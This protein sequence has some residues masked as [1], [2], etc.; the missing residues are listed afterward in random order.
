MSNELSLLPSWLNSLVIWMQQGDKRGKYAL[1][2]AVNHYFPGTVVRYRT[3]IGDFYAPC[4]EWC[5]WYLGGPEKYYLD[6]FTPF[7][8]LINDLGTPFVFFDLGAD[9][10][11]VSA[12]V[13][14]HCRLLNQ[15]IAFEPNCGAFSLLQHNLAS[16]CRSA[17]AENKAVSDFEGSATLVTRSRSLGDHEGYLSPN[18]ENDHIGN[19]S[20]PTLVTSLDA[21]LKQTQ[22]YLAPLIVLKIDVEG[23]EIQAINGAVE[24]IKHADQC[25]LLIEIHPEVL[26][27]QNQTPEDIFDAV[28]RIRAV[29]WLIPKRNNQPVDRS[30]PLFSQ[31]KHAQY[32]IIATSH[33]PKQ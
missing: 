13:A 11:T 3:A 32:D 4:E 5:F 21:Y 9:I 12:L 19:H 22:L 2:K 16:C 24:L 33:S 8:T 31:V 1:Y 10:G 23:Q 17:R 26:Q 6:E 30:R 28:E 15:V 25:V 29:N 14:T 27:K 18:T 7:L 20:N